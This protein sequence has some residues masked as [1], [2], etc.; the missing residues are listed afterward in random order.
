MNP[1]PAFIKSLDE[2]EQ[3]NPA[4]VQYMKRHNG[5]RFV[6]CNVV[7]GSFP[8]GSSGPCVYGYFVVDM[9]EVERAFSMSLIKQDFIVVSVPSGKA[10]YFTGKQKAVSYPRDVQNIAAFCKRFGAGGKYGC[11]QDARGR[12]HC[13]DHHYVDEKDERLPVEEEIRTAIAAAAQRA[14]IT[15][16]L[17]RA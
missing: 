16:G 6:D 1:R 9:V 7:I 13:A 2:V 14:R 12:W 5:A 11:G 17:T 8:S 10:E 15:L 3:D 4:L